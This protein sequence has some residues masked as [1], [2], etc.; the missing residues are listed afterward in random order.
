MHLVGRDPQLASLRAALDAVARGGSRVV[1]LRGEPGIGKTSLVHEVRRQAARTGL[2]VRAGRATELEQSLP[3]ALVESAGLLT[4]GDHGT[5]GPGEGPGGARGTAVEV[6]RSVAQELTALAGR[7]VLALLFDDVHWADDASLD[8]LAVLLTRPPEV[9]GLYLLAGRPGPVLDALLRVTVSSPLPSSVVEVEPLPR[10]DTY[11]LLESLGSAPAEEVVDASGGNPLLLKELA[12]HRGDDLPPSVVAA[13]EAEVLRLSPA[14]AE[15][16]RC[17]A[18][19]GDPFVIETARRTAGLDEA[20]GHAAVDELVAMRLVR[21]GR[22]L[23]EL[24]FR[25][26]VI[27]TAI[28]EAGSVAA[29]I[30]RHR[31][32]AQ[33]LA[34]SG[35]QPADVARHLAQVAAP[36]DAEAAGTLRAAADEARRGAPSIAA[37]WYLAADRIDPPTEPGRFADLADVL[38]R[39]GRLVEA[40]ACVERGLAL[41]SVGEADRYRLVLAAASMERLLGRPTEAERRLARVDEDVLLPSDRAL[42]YAARAASAFDAG[43]FHRVGALARTAAGLGGGHLVAAAATAAMSAMMS[44]FERD[45]D[46]SARFAAEATRLI[47]RASDEEIAADAELATMVP[48]ALVQLDLL[49]ETLAVSRRAAEATRRSG[50]DVAAV[51]LAVAEPL[52]LGLLGRTAEAVTASRETV[53]AAR[54][55]RLDQ[56]LQWALWLHAWLLLEADDVEGALAAAQESV[57][58]AQVLADSTLVTI[59]R[60]VLGST[61]IVAGRPQD[62]VPLLAAH[63]EVGWVCRWAPRLVEGYLAL[64][65]RAAAAAHVERVRTLD[66]DL[67]IPSTSVGVHQ[68]AAVLALADG[69]PRA[70]LA[71][72]RLATAAARAAGMRVEE[73]RGLILCGRGRAPTDV[74]AASDTWREA[75]RIAEAAGARRLAREAARELRRSGRRVASAAPRNQGARQA[76]PGVMDPLAALSAREREVAGLVAAGLTNKQIAQR[77][78]VTDKTVEAHVS[79]ALA[80]AGVTSRAALA[81]V[82][83]TAGHPAQH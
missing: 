25:H 61:L 31:R 83:V 24:R 67:G 63:D 76:G 19:L 74:A 69:D 34:E 21:P 81:A 38:L 49:E 2:L 82:V 45:H 40:L 39:S 72:A 66:A 77:L 23:A 62:G 27:R 60:S 17:G 41:P 47:G 56:P 29:R 36:G 20:E 10:A 33:V 80:K 79:R 22:V 9:P 26:P 53:L 12:A 28:V 3:Y 14:A 32:A 58:L 48:W 42:L 64:G 46:A 75:Y 11:L 68:A 65:D 18:E 7:R 4:A 70:A 16:V 71:E 13:T 15:L 8:V 50:N 35:A 37:E 44:R 30:D 5:A 78:F 51:S 1:V 54:L 43:E 73:A 55:T 57:G 59:A 6:G 52:A